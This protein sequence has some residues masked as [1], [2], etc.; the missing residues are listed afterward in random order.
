MNFRRLQRLAHGGLLLASALSLVVPSVAQ[1]PAP[2]DPPSIVQSEPKKQSGTLN[3]ARFA[4][5]VTGLLDQLDK[6]NEQVRAEAEK[7]LLELGPAVLVH[8]PRFRSSD[9]G[10]FRD[11]VERIRDTMQSKAIGEYAEP[12]TVSLNGKFSAA[13]VLI[14]IMDQTDNNISVTS[15]PLNGSTSISIESRFGRPSILSWIRWGWRR[16]HRRPTDRSN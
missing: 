4:S 1:E 14:E 9:S 12:A 2:A 10:A 16:P 5:Q 3:Q 13:D 7:K 15:F 6:G 11:A 8:L